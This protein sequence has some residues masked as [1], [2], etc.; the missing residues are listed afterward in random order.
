MPITE[1]KWW[2]HVRPRSQKERESRQRDGLG[3][4]TGY[5]REGTPPPH[6]TLVSD[7][8]IPVYEDANDERSISLLAFRME[9]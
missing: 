6:L 2:I 9:L 4:R 1:R 7:G 5:L 3:Y 8:D